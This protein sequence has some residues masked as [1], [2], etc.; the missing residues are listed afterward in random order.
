MFNSITSKIIDG[1]KKIAFSM[2]YNPMW[3]KIARSQTLQG[4]FDKTTKTWIFENN[5]ATVTKVRAKLR[6]VFGYDDQSISSDFIDIR[7][8]FM[9]NTKSE[10]DKEIY[11]L[12]RQLVY[13]HLLDSFH[14]EGRWVSDIGGIDDET[15]GIYTYQNSRYREITIYKGT[16][17]E[18]ENVGKEILTGLEQD[19]DGKY[20]Y[21]K[22]GIY[23]KIEVI[24]NTNTEVVIANLKTDILALEKQLNEKKTAL[25]RLTSQKEPQPSAT[26]NS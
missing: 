4:D 6:T 25:K 26:S 16:E 3:P 17:I 24:N 8:V 15:D 11:I 12:G 9:S 22:G 5:P 19:N 13:Y 1:G 18:L 14:V 21:K 7:L 2:P 20:I 23:A 10:R